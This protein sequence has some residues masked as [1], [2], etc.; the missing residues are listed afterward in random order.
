MTRFI[1]FDT[2]TFR[3][4]AIQISDG[5]LLSRLKN[6]GCPL[7]RYNTNSE[8]IINLLKFEIMSGRF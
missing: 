4:Y 1:S 2:D 5:F 7:S 6:L 8:E 3:R